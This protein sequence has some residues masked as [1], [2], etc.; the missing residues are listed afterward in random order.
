MTGTEGASPGTVLITGATGALGP[1]VI[2]AFAS[3][4][5]HIR[6]LSRHTPRAGT[7]AAAYPHVAADI[8]DRE[9]VERAVS[10]ATAV[11]HMAALLHVLD[12]KAD[13]LPEY[14][15]VNIDGTSVVLDAARRSGVRR[16]VFISSIAVY[17]ASLDFTDEQA[18][19]RPETPYASTKLEAE[20][21]VCR[22]TSADGSPLGVVLRLG[23]V[24]GPSIKG[25]Y[26]RLV[27]SLARG[28]FVPVGNGT[29]RRTLVFEDDAAEAIVLAASHALAAGRYFN[30][31]DGQVHTVAAIT[32][33]I[34]RALGRRPPRL[35]VP[36]G[37]A[38]ALVACNQVAFRLARRRPPITPATLE[39]Y[40]ED[41]AVRGERIREA[42]GFEPSWS[43]E[44]GWRR[45]I[46]QMRDEGR[47]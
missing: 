42:L 8:T 22:A 43:L 36:L 14:R 15:R 5:W 19:P 25:N 41:V 40:A 46:E 11:V 17:G 2:R 31:T 27:W 33:A 23:A 7:A 16:V 1:G 37:V 28:W 3:T 32:G 34:C 44:D 47:L 39:K 21:L 13:L 20:G 26:E 38:R 12:P 35:S 6:T 30:V 18:E 29:N 45:T 4:G 10:G 9:A 24:Y